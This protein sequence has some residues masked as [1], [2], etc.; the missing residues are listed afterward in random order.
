MYAAAGI[1][2][3]L[4]LYAHCVRLGTLRFSECTSLSMYFV[5]LC[6][7]YIRG[8]SWRTCPL[9]WGAVTECSL[10]KCV[11]LCANRIFVVHCK[12]VYSV[13]SLHGGPVSVH[14]GIC[15]L[16]GCVLIAIVVHCIYNVYIHLYACIC[17][18]TWWVCTREYVPCMAVCW[19]HLYTL[20]LQRVHPQACIC[21]ATWWVCTREYVPCMAVCWLQLYTLPLQ[22]VHPQACICIATRRSRHPGICTL[23]GCVL[24][25]L[26][27]HGDTVCICSTLRCSVYTPERVLFTCVFTQYVLRT[28]AHLPC[29]C[30]VPTRVSTLHLF[31]VHASWYL[32]P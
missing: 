21:T 30:L 29:F 13:C 9:H 10:L 2:V 31:N 14:A 11:E 1:L 24:I 28:V 15:T 25:A 26:T 6:T 32:T 5:W 19:L 8:T 12:T 20:P 7:D 18:A 22:R 3:S 16:Y 23:Y 17:I 4:H 27:V